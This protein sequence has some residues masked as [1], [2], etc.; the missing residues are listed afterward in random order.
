MMSSSGV[1]WRWLWT[2]NAHFILILHQT[3]C[4]RAG[5]MCACTY[6]RKV[7]RCCEPNLP[8][9]SVAMRCA[10]LNASS[11]DFAILPELPA[12]F[13]VCASQNIRSS[14]HEDNIGSPA[15]TGHCPA[16]HSYERRLAVA[17]L[18][19]CAWQQ[20][21]VARSTLGCA[22]RPIVPQQNTCCR[23]S[24]E[25]ETHHAMWNTAVLTASKVPAAVWC[26]ITHIVP[27]LRQTNKVITSA[28]HNG[29]THT[30]LGS[31]SK[32]FF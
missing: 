15:I 2:E 28:I 29:A 25:C 27:A 21:C 17:D 24:R 3:V 31:V 14:T 20:C 1:L 23:D 7:F 5:R 30:A 26:V 32:C 10:V 9:V 12:T 6:F 13:L 18:L 19:H 4:S 11:F 22:V 16:T 8:R